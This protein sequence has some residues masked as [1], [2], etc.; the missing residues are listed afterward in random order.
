MHHEPLENLLKQTAEPNTQSPGRILVGLGWSL[1]S[2]IFSKFSDD[3]L[4]LQRP[5]F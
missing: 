2:L 4:L 5:H 3:A 1:R